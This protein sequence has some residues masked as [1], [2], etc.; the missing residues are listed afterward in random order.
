MLCF[1]LCRPSP[2]C[3]DGQ[4]G[5]REIRREIEQRDVTLD[6]I[7][8]VF[9]RPK[10][11]HFYIFTFLHFSI[12]IKSLHMHFELNGFGGA[13]PLPNIQGLMVVCV[14]SK[15]GLWFRG[16]ARSFSEGGQLVG[17]GWVGVGSAARG[18]SHSFVRVRGT[19]SER[20]SRQ[21]ERGNLLFPPHPIP[22]P[23][24]G[25]S[26]SARRPPARQ[27]RPRGQ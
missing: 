24:S 3:P 18:S 25:V 8:R 27:T 7:L 26:K 19:S 16:M 13:H 9:A 10:K 22:A 12:L 2:F 20:K 23:L 14:F 17:V 15:C 4:M 6:L 1:C 11:S 21:R 5:G